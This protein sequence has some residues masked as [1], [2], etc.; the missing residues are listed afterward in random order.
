MKILVSVDMEGISGVV[1]GNGLGIAP[2]VLHAGRI[3]RAVRR[4]VAADAVGLNQIDGSDRLFAGLIEPVGGRAA[5][6]RM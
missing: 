3:E 2:A 5:V 1:S 6:G 4:R